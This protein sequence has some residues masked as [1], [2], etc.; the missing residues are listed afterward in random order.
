LL[1][2][3]LPLV[4]VCSGYIATIMV[5]WLAPILLLKST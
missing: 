3:E 4:A 5:Q 1:L 2:A